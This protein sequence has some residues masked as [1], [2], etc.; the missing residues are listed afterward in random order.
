MF[1]VSACNLFIVFK[2]TISLLTFIDPSLTV[3]ALSAIMSHTAER[4]S[5][6]IFWGGNAYYH[7]YLGVPE[8]VLSYIED[9]TVTNRE[10]TLICASYYI[11]VVPTASWTKVAR[12]LYY[13]GEMKALKRAEEFLSKG[14]IIQSP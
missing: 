8:C 6:R 9:S 3:E 1:A 14:R 2:I 12:C 11:D 4:C 13:Y 5:W 10:R 7:S